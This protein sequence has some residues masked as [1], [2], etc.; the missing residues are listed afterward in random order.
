MNKKKGPGEEVQGVPVQ[1]VNALDTTHNSSISHKEETKTTLYSS[2]KK[3]YEIIQGNVDGS[4][5]NRK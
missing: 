4:K 3:D 1:R 2:A 5:L